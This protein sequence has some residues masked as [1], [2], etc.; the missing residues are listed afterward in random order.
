MKL[1]EE[2]KA[3]SSKW[4]KTKG[5]DYQNFYWQNC[6]VGFS[7]NSE[8]LDIVKNYVFYLKN[9]HKN[10]TFKEEYVAMLERGLIEYDDKYLW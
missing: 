4:I 1:I 7:V 5:E 8:Q 3:H 10:K 6:Y 9:H 2:L